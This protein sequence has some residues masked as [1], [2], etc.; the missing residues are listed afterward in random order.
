[1]RDYQ[2][3]QQKMLTLCRC[4]QYPIDVYYHG[5]RC[6]TPICATPCFEEYHTKETHKNQAPRNVRGK[7]THKNKA[8]Q[9][10]RQGD[11][12]FATPT[13]LILGHAES[14]YQNIS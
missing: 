7:G 8:P 5:Y 3:C 6:D 2:I 9:C 14:E 12:I 4:Q 11:H 13:S 10:E 1:M